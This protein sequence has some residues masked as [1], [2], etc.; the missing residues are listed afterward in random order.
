MS[1]W[2]AVLSAL[3]ARQDLTP[4]QA[5]WAMG[6]VMAG[7]ATP[8]QIAGFAV[9]LRAKG[10]TPGE[11][12]ALVGVM[13]DRAR[14]CPVDGPVVDTCGTGGDRAHTVN[15]STMAAFVVAGAGLRVV[16]HG[17]RAAS[18]TCGSADLLEELGVRIDLE[19]ALV[20]RCAAE[21]G[22]AFCFAPVFH[23]ALRHT[24]VPRRELGVGTVFNFLGPLTNPARPL[25]QAVGV[26]DAR[27]A[28]VMAGVLAARGASALVFRGDDGLDELT[29]ATT[30]RVWVVAGG[31]VTEETF[32][33]ASLGIGP[34]EPDALRGGDAPVNADVAR[35]FLSGEAGPVRDAVL[36]N[37]AA[38]LAAAGA[39]PGGPLASRL[40][41]GV[42]LG[43]RAVDSGDAAAALDRW[44]SV[45]RALAG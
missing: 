3:L 25:A 20:A 17:N 28:P 8:S 41:A 13:L 43:A 15:I 18:S 16:K 19:P 35:A 7:D 30:S 36:L 4:E 23:P 5:A 6:E 39:V 14:P 9:A 10:E 32:D 42:A 12:A 29:T 45:S 33:P 31:A 44:V 38:A 2:P 22:V 40:G 21:A 24:A 26:A 27:M 37:A 1:A 11:L 34:P